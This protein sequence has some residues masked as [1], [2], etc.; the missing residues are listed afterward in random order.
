ME[1]TAASAMGKILERIIYN[2][3]L[4]VVEENG[5][6][7]DQQYGFRKH[8]ST[9]DAIKAVVDTSSAAIEG[10]RWSRGTIEYY[11]GVTLDVKNAFNA[12]CWH[13]IRLSLAAANTPCYL[14][15]IISSYLSKDTARI[16]AGAPQGSVLGPLL[17]IEMYDGLL[18]LKLSKGVKIVGFADDIAI[19]AVAEHIHE[20]EVATCEA[21]I[22]IRRWLK[23]AEFKLAEHRTEAVL[24][25]G[26][27]NVE[28]LSIQ[29]EEQTILSKES[30]KYLG[31]MLDNRLSYKEHVGFVNK[32]AARLQTV[33]SGILPNIGAP[34]HGSVLA[35]MVPI[36]IFAD[37]MSRVYNWRQPIDRTAWMTARM[38]S[39]V[40]HL[41]K[42]PM[43][44]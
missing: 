23:N 30:L 33:L 7:S 34:K 35:G 43:D 14:R 2:R 15:R 17:W 24:I 10:E 26:R 21:I 5:A 19:V 29:V 16:T 38:P 13:F 3:L 20:V 44:L 28:Y 8:R 27:K 9:V 42:R 41:R 32:K 36:D 12:A 25:T 37:E 31:V 6:L 22:Q 11:A 40:G 1:G 18:R 4:K 39:T